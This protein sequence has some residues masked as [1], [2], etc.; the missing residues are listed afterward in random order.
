MALR[1]VL[2]G[3][4]VDRPDHG[5]SLKR[6]LSPGLPPDRLINDGVLYPLLRRLEQDGLLRSRSE[7]HAG[8]DRRSFQAT[9]RGRRAFLVWLRS[10]VDEDY[11]PT[12]ELYVGHPLVKLLFSDHL[13]DVERLGK[14]ANHSRGVRERLATLERLRAVTDPRGA[15]ALNSAW[16]DL[17]IAQQQQRLV[18]LQALLDQLRASAQ[19]QP[20]EPVCHS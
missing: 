19:P 5:Y 18:G 1:D 20:E 3:L 13:T 16:L 17:E 10:D 4:V 15:H 11:E 2:V 14:L 6:R 9:T 12:Y 8:R 7:R